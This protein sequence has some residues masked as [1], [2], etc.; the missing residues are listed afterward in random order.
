MPVLNEVLRFG[1]RSGFFRTAAQA[2]GRRENGE[3]FLA[4]LWFSTYVARDGVQLAAILVDSS[5]EMRDREQQNL[6]NLSAS[7]RL[8]A[9]AVLHE[10]RNICSAISVVYSNL[11]DRKEPCR[12]DEIQGLG[13][14]ITGLGRVAS[15]EL[16]GTAP[17]PLEAV[18]LQQILDELRII[19]EP[20]WHEIEGSVCLSLEDR[21]VRVQ[22]DRYG[23]M[24]VFLNLS[25]NGHRA[26]Q[27]M[28]VREL[29][30]GVTTLDRLARI[31]FS[32][33]GCGV[34]Y[35]QHLFQP[36]QEN[37]KLTGLGLFISRALVRGFGGEMWFEPLADGSSFVVELPLAAPGKYDV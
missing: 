35:P 33:T 5:E 9:A 24:Q 27:T 26:V 7:S 36:F 1:T 16:H 15:L 17:E 21:A 8:V 3:M 20:S 22:A 10:V 28:P 12:I 37:A 14:L 19:I 30:I 32:D 23:L 13:S 4:D 2:P 29:R 11:R 6:R 34:P 18:P 25:Q 31:T